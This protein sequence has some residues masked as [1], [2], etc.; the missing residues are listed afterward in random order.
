MA[1]Y[2]D[3]ITVLMCTFLVMFAMSSVNAAKF[4]QL[5]NSLQTGFGVVKTQKVDTASGVVVPPKDATKTDP[6]DLAPIALAKIELDRLKDLQAQIERSLAKKGLDKDVSFT[7]DQRGLTVGLIGNTTFFHTN[8]ADLTPS[9]KQVIATIAPIIAHAGNRISMEGHA[10]Q[11]P[12]LPPYPTNWELAAAR[13]V[14]VLRELDSAGVPGDRL[15]AVSYGDT[16]AAVNGSSSSA[17]AQDRRVDVVVL[18][19]Q[20]EAVRQLIPLLLKGQG[21][22]GGTQSERGSAR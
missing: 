12:P 22:G 1:S 21:E 9:A 14:S 7:I 3:M 2:L 19:D 4:N 20:P 13:A 18:S 16:H 11:R 6:K 10:D 5:K 15:D 8:L 17:L